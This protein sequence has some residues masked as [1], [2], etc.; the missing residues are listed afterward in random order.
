M[1]ATLRK[2]LIPVGVIWFLALFVA[3]FMAYFGTSADAGGVTD[4]L[5]RSLSE[6]PGLM[7]IFFGQERMWA[8]WAWF[9]G[10]MI[11]FWGSVALA[12]KIRLW[13]EE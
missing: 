9:A 12:V 6:V 2:I 4:G 13:L 11:L 10:D 1:K 5:G 7:R 8:G 3:G